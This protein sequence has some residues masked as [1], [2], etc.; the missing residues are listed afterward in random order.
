MNDDTYGGPL[1]SARNLNKTYPDGLVHAVADLDL[2]VPRGEYLAIMGPSGSGKSSLLNLLG[3]LDTADSGELLFDGKP[4]GTSAELDQFRS[5][6]VGFVFQSFHLM[7]TLTALEN[8]QIPMFEGELPA[9]QRREKAAELLELVGMAHRSKHMPMKL[10]VGERQRVAIARSLANDPVLLCGDEPTGNLDS[11]TA[12]DILD[13]FDS[14][15]RD[16]EMTRVIVTHSQE[17]ADRAERLIHIRDGK[18]EQDARV[19]KR[20]MSVV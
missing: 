12:D 4:L 16:R 1:I 14:R 15:H 11:R 20:E 8:V 17:V 3:G 18:V 19:E 5:H 13:L 7:P 10:S 9:K 6:Q 2:D